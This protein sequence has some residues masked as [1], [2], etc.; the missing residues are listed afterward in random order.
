M[1]QKPYGNQ[2]IYLDGQPVAETVDGGGWISSFVDITIAGD[3]RPL[4]G[5]DESPSPRAFL[6]GKMA[7]IAIDDHLLDAQ[8]VRRHFQTG[9]NEKR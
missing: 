6:H 5:A 2:T 9:A 4:G 8:R 7:E 1:D 3:P